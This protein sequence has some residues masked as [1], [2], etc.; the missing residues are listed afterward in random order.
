MRKMEYT[1][2]ADHEPI[3]KFVLASDAQSFCEMLTQYVDK[4]IRLESKDFTSVYDN[5]TIHMIP[6]EA[7]END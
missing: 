7:D 4:T 6:K 5:Y 3:A 1:V 2:T